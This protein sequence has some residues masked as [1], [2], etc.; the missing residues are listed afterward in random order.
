[1]KISEL[2]SIIFLKRMVVVKNSMMKT[3]GRPVIKAVLIYD[4]KTQASIYAKNYL[5]D[6]NIGPD[7]LSSL[8]HTSQLFVKHNH[9]IEKP[10]NNLLIDRFSLIL[11][12]EVL[13]VIDANNIHNNVFFHSNKKYSG[14]LSLANKIEYS[15]SSKIFDSLVNIIDKNY[16]QYEGVEKTVRSELD[17]VLEGIKY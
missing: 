1:M 4:T 9:M 11:D 6:I 10:I 16:Y 12:G 7:L 3:V 15:S 13:R 5:K 2:L 8:L 17:Q 14:V